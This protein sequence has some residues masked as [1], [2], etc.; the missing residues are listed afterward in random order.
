MT[1][2]LIIG[3]IFLVILFIAVVAQRAVMEH[4]TDRIT[5]LEEKIDEEENDD[6]DDID[7]GDDIDDEDTDLITEKSQS[8]T[9][10][11]VYGDKKALEKEWEIPSF[12]RKNK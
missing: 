11:K 1:F 6:I 2:W 3:I 12:L 7:Y 10:S 5:E 4:L 8:A 9:P